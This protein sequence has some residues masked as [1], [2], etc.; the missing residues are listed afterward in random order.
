MHEES[1]KIWAKEGKN[2]R[3]INESSPFMYDF[4]DWRDRLSPSCM[5]LPWSGTGPVG[6]TLCRIRSV[7]FKN[8]PTLSRGILLIGPKERHV[9]KASLFQ[10]FNLKPVSNKS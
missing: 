3:R 5:T 2:S 6:F 8:L 1:R 10:L 4:T 7:D 9:H